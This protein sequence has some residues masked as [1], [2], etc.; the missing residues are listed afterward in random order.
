M[1]ATGAAVRAHW[2]VT[3]PLTGLLQR[4]LVRLPERGYDSASGS[5]PQRRGSF[6]LQHEDLCGETYNP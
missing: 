3:V 4:E 2:L 5:R 1:T 6:V